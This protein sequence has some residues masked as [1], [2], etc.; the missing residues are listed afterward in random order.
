MDLDNLRRDLSELKRD[1]YRN[2]D[3][4]VF[5]PVALFIGAGAALSLAYL[6]YC[7]VA[8]GVHA[9]AF[10]TARKRGRESA[11][12]ACAGAGVG[13]RADDMGKLRPA[14]HRPKSKAF[15]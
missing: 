15:F 4:R 12:S 14:H 9:I 2:G 6:V 3:R 10:A 7:A 1:A 5:G 8:P 13:H 11:S